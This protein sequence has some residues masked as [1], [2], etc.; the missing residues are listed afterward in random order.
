MKLCAK[1]QLIWAQQTL[2][3][4]ESLSWEKMICDTRGGNLLFLLCY[5]SFTDISSILAFI[6]SD[7]NAVLKESRFVGT[8]HMYVEAF[9]TFFHVQVPHNLILLLHSKF[10]SS[11]LDLRFWTTWQHTAWFYRVGVCVFD[12]DAFPNC[13]F[14]ILGWSCVCVR[15]HGRCWKPDGWGP[16]GSHISAVVGHIT[17]QW[18]HCT[19]QPPSG[20]RGAFFLLLFFVV[21][22]CHS[23]WKAERGEILEG[24]DTVALEHDQFS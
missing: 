19:Q 23:V 2:T 13:V 17:N 8:L 10:R 12:I 1:Q 9:K 5:C 21:F 20:S 15:G 22:Y 6:S 3:T 4:A 7:T 24:L 18:P 14:P 16:G 11:V